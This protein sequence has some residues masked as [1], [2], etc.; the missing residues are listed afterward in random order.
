[1]Q[2]FSGI[3][4]LKIDIANCYGKDKDLWQSRID[5]F[6]FNEVSLEE[7]V[8]YADEPYL[9]AKAVYAYRDTMSGIPTGHNMFLDATASGLQ[10]MACLAG[11]LETA[12]HVNLV[13]TGKRED[14][15]T[16]I[17]DE[18]NLSLSPMIQVMRKLIKQPA[19]VHFYNKMSHEEL[20]AEQELVFYEVLL[21][22]FTG[23]E[24]VKD[25]IN[26]YWN[27]DALE[28]S[29]Y[30]PNGRKAVCKVTEMVDARIEVD[31]LDGT[32]FTYRFEANQSSSKSSSLVPNIIQ[33][34]DAYIVDEMVLRAKKQGFELAHIHDAFT[35]QC[36]YG[37]KVR[38]NY[39][40]ILCEIADSDLLASI[41][42][43][44]SG[45][46][47][48]INKTIDNLSDYIKEAEYLLS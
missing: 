26:E 27:P 42:S 4:Y 37:N 34:I 43:D 41:L 24:E 10:I 3:D 39:K 5:W 2:T 23:A 1:M 25:L 38:Q 11:C 21:N 35:F 18:M 30:L 22:S 20:S 6:D 32:T 48:E 47:V 17:A 45:E 31:E 19:M 15:Y 28:H 40:D 29:W 36:K 12:K 33:S 7:L 16:Y 44:I 8:P 46:K 13:N 9:M 14:V